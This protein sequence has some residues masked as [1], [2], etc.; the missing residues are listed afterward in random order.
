MLKL[1]S[2]SQD[3]DNDEDGVEAWKQKETS[4][5]GLGLL[6]RLENQAGL[7]IGLSC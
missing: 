7:L 3:N 2:C 1:F 4:N 5:L 6:W